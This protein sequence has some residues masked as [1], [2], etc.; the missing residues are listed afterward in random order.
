MKKIK[1]KKLN[2]LLISFIYLF[3]SNLKSD[4][5][6]ISGLGYIKPGE[7]RVD[8]EINPLPLGLSFVPMIAYRGERLSVFGPNINYALIKG[9]ISL[10]L[11]LNTSGDPFK[12]HEINQS[13]TAINGGVSLR[14]LFLTLNYESDI[15]NV[16]DGNLMKASIGWRFPLFDNLMF[17]P[18]FG[19]EF[20][21]HSY[22]NHYF[23]VE[24]SE[25]GYFSFYE[26]NSAVNDHYGFGLI[27]KLTEMNSLSLNYSFKKLDKVIYD[28]PTVSKKEY[29]TFSV[30]WSYVL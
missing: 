2:L 28:S 22:V 5:K 9:A 16:Y 23:G 24:K 21:N 27:F 26:T 11:R 1:M 7:F 29:D 15:S 4:D 20:L 3:S 17:T 6:F 30:F 19:K 8:N 18:N 14:L 25:V 10:G 12:S 13:G